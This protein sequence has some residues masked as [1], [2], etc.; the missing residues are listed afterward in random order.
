MKCPRDGTELVAVEFMGMHLE[1]CHRC[2]G[3]WFDRGELERIRDAKIPDIEETLEEKYGNPSY[4]EGHVEGYM[5][6]PRC[7]ARLQEQLYTYQDVVRVDRCENCMGFWVDD[8]ELN[9][10]CG[11]KKQLDEA[12]EAKG[13]FRAVFEKFGG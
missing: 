8:T 10:I 5:R 1:K 3:I 11:E 13:F 6:C 4:D 7:G 2:D 9:R 12:G